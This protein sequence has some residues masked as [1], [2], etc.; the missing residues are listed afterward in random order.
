MLNQIELR[1]KKTKLVNKD[2]NKTRVNKVN[3][4]HEITSFKQNKK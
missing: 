4:K 1:A 2:T 3:L